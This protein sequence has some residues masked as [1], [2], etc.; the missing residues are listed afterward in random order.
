MASVFGI[1]APEREAKSL[2][3]RTI[4]LAVPMPSARQRAWK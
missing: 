2:E 1:E 3:A 4:S